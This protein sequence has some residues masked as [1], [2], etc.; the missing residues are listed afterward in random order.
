M[1]EL[2][3]RN[4]FAGRHPSYEKRKMTVGQI[5]R[6][7]RYDKAFDSTRKQKRYRAELNRENRRLG[8]YGNGDK[9][10]VSH[11]KKGKL[12]LEPQ[13]LNRARNRGKK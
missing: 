2:N 9:K 5:R 12:V 11:T 6:K 13:S 4:R 10:D 3:K 1:P 7:R 8:T